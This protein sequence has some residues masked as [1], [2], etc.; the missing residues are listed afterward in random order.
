MLSEVD[1][2]GI[3]VAPIVVYCI[4]AIPLFLIFRSA[5]WHLGVLRQIWQPAL[6]ELSV[7]VTL[8]ALLILA[9]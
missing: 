3:Y 9:V 7:Y 5:L 6:F 2:G 1:L 8:L 4:A